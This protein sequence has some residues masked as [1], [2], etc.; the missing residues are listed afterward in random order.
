M[1]SLTV[2]PRIP[3]SIGDLALE[4]TLHEWLGSSRMVRKPK[5]VPLF[6]ASENSSIPMSVVE[7]GCGTGVWLA[8]MQ[9]HGVR[10]I[11]AIDGPWIRHGQPHIPLCSLLRHEAHK[12]ACLFL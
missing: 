4:H 11:V 9:K 12:S 6:R 1:L 10:D 7:I 2:V 5:P 3:G 8:E